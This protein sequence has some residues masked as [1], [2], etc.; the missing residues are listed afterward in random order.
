M[1]FIDDFL[2]SWREYR[3]PGYYDGFD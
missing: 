1:S 3:E 2:A